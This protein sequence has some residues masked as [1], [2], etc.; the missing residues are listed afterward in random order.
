MHNELPDTLTDEA[1]FL[2]QRS[3]GN[4]FDSKQFI[5]C[6]YRSRF[7][8]MPFFYGV[9]CHQTR[10]SFFLLSN[11][12]WLIIFGSSTQTGSQRTISI[13]HI[14]VSVTASNRDLSSTIC[15]TVL[16]RS[17]KLVRL[18]S[19]YLGSSLIRADDVHYLVSFL[20]KVDK[21]RVR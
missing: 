15:I 4:S 6:L 12:R 10:W 20:S 5:F 21:T 14:L 16:L 9:R 19:R 7:D 13:S 1:S 17:T 2:L 11:Q 3:E 8:G 18:E